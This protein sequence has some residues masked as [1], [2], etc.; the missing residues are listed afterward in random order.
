[1]TAIV[2]GGNFLGVDAFTL[3]IAIGALIVTRFGLTS[4]AKGNQELE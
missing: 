2:S 1:M 3:Q 4:C